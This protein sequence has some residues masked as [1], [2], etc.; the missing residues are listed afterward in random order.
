MVKRVKPNLLRQRRLRAAAAAVMPAD[1]AVCSVA[2]APGGDVGQSSPQ[3]PATESATS[4]S[5]SK[6][7]KSKS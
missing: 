2:D 7:T 5:K 6:S 4:K 3:N 1:G